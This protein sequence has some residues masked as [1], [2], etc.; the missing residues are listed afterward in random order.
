MSTETKPLDVARAAADVATHGDTPET[1]DALGRLARHV[2]DICS[3]FV[4]GLEET[5]GREGVPYALASAE[6]IAALWRLA[7]TFQLLDERE[8]VAVIEQAM[9]HVDDEASYPSE[10][11]RTLRSLDRQFHRDAA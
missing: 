9:V 2:D 10:R 7:D 4:L 5:I 8:L 1:V 3:M 11:T 6:G